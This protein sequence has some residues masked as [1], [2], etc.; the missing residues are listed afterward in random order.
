MPNFQPLKKLLKLA[1]KI[2]ENIIFYKKIILEMD[3][4][5]LWNTFSEKLEGIFS[6]NP[7]TIKISNQSILEGQISKIL[8]HS[9]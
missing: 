1:N 7:F 2:P 5:T 6:Y 9:V 8:A 3:K 4:N